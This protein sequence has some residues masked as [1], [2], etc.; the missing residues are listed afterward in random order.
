MTSLCPLLVCLLVSGQPAVE[1]DVVVRGAT[2]YDGSGAAG[3]VG[4]VAVRGERIVAVGKF[5]VAGA[6]REIDGKGL[7]L[8]PGFIDLHTHSDYPLEKPA[9]RANRNYLHQGVTTVVTGNCGAGPV[10]VASYFQGLESGKVGTNVIHQVP[11]NN[12]RRRV[13]KNAN[14]APT[15]DELRKMEELVDR[16]MTDGAWGLS[17]GLIYNPGTYAKTDELIALAKVAA[18]HGGFYASHIRDEGAGVLAAIDEAL[19][20]GREAGLPIHI[21]HLKASGQRNWGKAAD[22][23]ALIEKARKAGQTVS[24][25]QYPY[26]AS[27]TSLSATVIPT[28]FREGEGKDYLNRLN[29]PQELARLRPL[30]AASLERRQN[31]K[32]IRIA[33]YKA[34]PAWN[35]KDLAAIAALEKRPALDIVLEIERNGGAQIVNFGMSEEDVRLIMRQPFVATASDGASMVPSPGT[36]P[37]PRSYGC[38]PRKIGRYAIEDKIITLEHALRSCSGLPAD[39]LKLPERGYLKVGH[40][41]D[42]VVLDPKTFRDAATFD[43]PHQYAPGVRYLFVNGKLAIDDGK[44]TGVLAGK[45]LRHKEGDAKSEEKK[46][47]RKPKFTI[48]KETTYVNGPLYEDGT[49]DYPTALNERLRKGVTPDNNA[50]VLIWK[51][52]GPRPEGKQMPAEYFKWLGIDEPP[53]KGEY[54]I[55]QSRYIR[56]QLKIEAGPALEAFQNEEIDRAFARPWTAKQYPRVAAWLKINEK[57]LALIAQAIE[58]PQYFSP[59]VP[60]RTKEGSSGGLISALLPAVQK[61]REVAQALTIRAMLA[62]AEGRLEDARRDLLACH[63]LGRLVARGSTLIEGLVGIAIDTVASNADVALLE[64]AGTDPKVDVKTLQGWLRD[65]Q[66]LPPMPALA[67][68]V[69]LG[70]RFGSLDSMMLVARGGLPALESLSGGMPPKDANAFMKHALDDV[71]WDPA[72]RL[73]NQWFDRIAFAL[74]IQDRAARQRQLQRLDQDLKKLRAEVTQPGAMG[75]FLFGI[76]TTNEKRGEVVGKVMITLL[77]PA[78]L[79][80]QQAH[81]RSEQTQRNLHIAFA[82]AC[83]HREHGRYPDKLDALVPKYLERVS[84][85]LFSGRPLIYL[86]SEKGYL[87]YSVGANGRDDGGQGYSDGV[88]TDDLSVRMPLPEPRRK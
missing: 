82:L 59:L 72:L 62:L 21:S 52:L 65:V 70:E 85:D 88:G 18:R 66:R 32:S 68:Q 50:V 51:A 10:D 78:I 53:E 24:A 87:L 75:T 79:K 20:I 49:I 6:P 39:I 7:V 40:Y 83:Y 25:D 80:V 73:A 4:D 45:V 64:R 16:A 30:V 33:S 13:M 77:M 74:S 38:F 60:T 11:H 8:A 48:G 29:D 81:D 57:P 86:P 23:V 54:F 1:A 42:V 37:H 3:V 61:C 9:T 15:A 71:N 26:I 27:S 46:A 22:E 84:Q 14:R 35:G 47:Q 5:A 43:K 28:S 17:T 44:F 56:E 34:K 36:V 69:N 55:P 58:R 63:R 41:A 2:L 67:E 19:T 12:V 76:L 31:G